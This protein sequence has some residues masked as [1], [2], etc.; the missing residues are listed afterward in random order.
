MDCVDV[1]FQYAHFTK[2]MQQKWRRIP[3]KQLEGCNPDQRHGADQD[4][5]LQHVDC[6]DD[7]QKT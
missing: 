7:Y 5:R 4:A 3:E 6:E 2:V 1:G